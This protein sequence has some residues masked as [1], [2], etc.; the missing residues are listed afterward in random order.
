VFNILFLIIA[1]FI[2]LCII[3]GA[4][5]GF[6]RSM[7]FL[8]STY[9]AVALAIVLITPLTGFTTQYTQLDEKIAD[10]VEAKVVSMLPEGVTADMTDMLTTNQQISI[11]Q[12]A[13]FPEVLKNKLI[14]NNNTS[15]YEL[16]G[17]SNFVEYIAAYIAGIV[18]KIITFL[19]SFI[20]FLLLLRLIFHAIERVAREG[21]L[22]GFNRFL[23]G[24]IGIAVALAFVWAFFLVL[25]IFCTT[26]WGQSLL[27]MVEQNPVLSFLFKNNVIMTYLG[28][29]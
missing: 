15:M 12:S 1:A 8:F 21:A 24:V 29:G 10:K 3:I 11:I 22:A 26:A 27:L 9:A 14:E 23:G 28:R 19:A 7:S 4:R 25:T 6:V 2:I 20:I 17:I 16:L 13:P 18:V 5:R